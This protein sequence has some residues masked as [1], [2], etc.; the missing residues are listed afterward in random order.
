MVFIDFNYSKFNKEDHSIMQFRDL[1]YVIVLAEHRN[2]SKAAQELCITQ[3]A[4]S[5]AIIRL[6]Q[7]FGTKLFNRQHNLVDPTSACQLLIE[8]GKA[9]LMMRKRL[10]QRQEES[11][12]MKIGRLKV[13]LTKLISRFYLPDVYREFHNQYPGIELILYEYTTVSLEEAVERGEVDLAIYPFFDKSDIL[14]YIPLI[15]ESMYLAVPKDHPIRNEQKSNHLEV[16]LIDFKNDGFILLSKG[17]RTRMVT[18]ALFTMAGFTPR[19]VFETQQSDTV[20]ALVGANMGVGIVPE[21]VGLFNAGNPGCLYYKISD[22]DASRQI[23][24]AYNKELYFSE[25]SKAFVNIFRTASIALMAQLKTF[26]DAQ[27]VG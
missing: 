20:N 15:T 9:I 3:P 22:V 14:N 5:Q 12:N 7:E 19:I 6:E 1:E 16:R 21:T 24:A 17:L 2:F 13:G 18:D 25:A 27:K 26:F 4:L 8:D 23:V 11:K 10:F